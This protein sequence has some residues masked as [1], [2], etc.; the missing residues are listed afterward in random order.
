MD[1]IIENLESINVM[2][3]WI[4]LLVISEPASRG[5]DETFHIFL[6]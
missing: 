4:L 3:I 5:E 2:L 1:C 6:T